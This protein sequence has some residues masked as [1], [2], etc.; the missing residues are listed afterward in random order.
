MCYSGSRLFTQLLEKM[1]DLHKILTAILFILDGCVLYVGLFS[2]SHSD[3]HTIRQRDH[4][5]ALGAL[6]TKTHHDIDKTHFTTPYL[7]EGVAV[8]R[9]FRATFL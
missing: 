1:L 6:S 7:R 5:Q 8:L 2:H 3:L 4:A 9:G